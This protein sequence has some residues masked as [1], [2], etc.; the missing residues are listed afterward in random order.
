MKNRRKKSALGWYLAFLTM[1]LYASP[2]MRD[3][4]AVETVQYI[5]CEEDAV[6]LDTL[7]AWQGYV[8]VNATGEWE[9]PAEAVSAAKRIL[10]SGVT[11][12][13][14]TRLTVSFLGIPIRSVRVIYEEERTVIA[15]GECIAISIQTQGVLIVGCTQMLDS[16]GNSIYPA[17]D[18]GLQAG[19]ILLSV[20]GTL[21]ESAAMLSSHLQQCQSDE[22]LF[23]VYERNGEVLETQITPVKDPQDGTYRLGIWIRDAMNGVGTLTYVDAQ[24]R[25]FGALGHSVT[26]MDTGAMLKV[27]TGAVVKAEHVQIAAS[28]SGSP[29]ELMGMTSG[30]SEK[31]GSL[32]I[33]CSFGIFG[34]LDTLL[35]LHSWNDRFVGLAHASEA[36]LGPAS[37]LCTLEDGVIGEYEVQILR[38][39]RQDRPQIKGILLEVTDQELLEKTGGIIQGMSGS[40]ILQD[41]RMIG[42]VTHVLVND[43]ARG[44]GVYLDWMVQTDS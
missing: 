37:I 5:R 43:P 26:D 21:L 15:G 23:I 33:N 6:C 44:Y 16:V 32:D 8:Q 10:T 25:R 13:E 39:M 2:V 1:I 38:L 29:G 12:P 20:N 42:A 18:A 31:I 30:S 19:D 24:T 22:P 17:N 36:H 28:Q 11:T 7:E 40:P 35:A 9:E 27:K 4:R 14:E 3:I 34:R 41:G